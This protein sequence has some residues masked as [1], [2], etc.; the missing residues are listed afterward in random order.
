MLH[1]NNRS[2]DIKEGAPIT[3][4]SLESKEQETSP[5]PRY[6]EASLIH[7]MEEKGIGRPSTYAPIISLIQDKGYVEKEYRYFI[8]TKLGEPIS[9]Y[10]ARSFP[11]L[12]ICHLLLIWKKNLMKLLKEK[13]S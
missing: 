10:L 5:P 6:N 8:P 1:K 3:L 7:I 9:D 13:N 11:I 4:T 2:I 12:L